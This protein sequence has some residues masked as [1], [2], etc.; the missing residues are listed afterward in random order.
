MTVQLIHAIPGRVRVKVGKLRGAAGPSAHL[1]HALRECDGIRNVSVSTVTA[2]VLVAHSRGIS[3][4]NIADLIERLVRDDAVAPAVGAACPI[5]GGR[6]RDVSSPRKWHLEH[7]DQVL[8]HFGVSPELGLAE[9]AVPERRAAHGHNRLPAASGRNVPTILAGQLTELPVALTAG[10]ALLALVSGGIGEA[11]LLVGIALLNAL[12]GT[13]V[14]SHAE[15]ILNAV[16]RAV[17]LRARVVRDG[18]ERELPFDQVVVGDVLELQA[19]TRIAADARVV[20]ARH[21][22]V[23]EAALTGES[24][25]VRKS[26]EPL[27]VAAAPISE[28][29]NMVYRGTLVVEGSGRAVVVAAGADTV[30]GRLQAFLGTLVPPEARVAREVQGLMRRCLKSGLAAAAVFAAVGALRGAGLLAIL[31]G[32][33]ALLASA[34]PAGLSTLTGGAFAL[35]QRDLRRN[36]I[37]VRRLRALGNL[38]GTQVVCFDKTG[39]LTLNR[40]TVAE[41][42]LPTGA[43]LRPTAANGSPAESISGH[44]GA[45]W[46][47]Q[48]LSLCNEARR[49]GDDPSLEGSS[50]EKALVRMAERTGLDVAAIRTEHPALELH[51]RNGRRPFME[52]LHRWGEQRRLRITKGS[53]TEVL[54]RCNRLHV[55][56]GPQPMSAQVREQVEAQNFRMAGSGQRVLGAAYRWEEDSAS[57]EGDD[58][59]WAGLVGLR[60]PVRS[61]A[62]EVIS[63]LHRAGIRTAV[64]TGDQSLTAHRIG[65]ELGLAGGDAL[66]I[67]DAV[68][69][70]N[71]HS[72]GLRSVVTRT[73]VFARLSPTQKLQVIQAYQHAGLSVVMVGDGFNDVLALKVADVGV[74][75]GR[76]SAELAKRTADLVLE[77]DDLAGL[78]RAIANGRAFFDNVRS[79]L[80]Y[81]LTSAHMDLAAALA[82]RS[83]WVGDV[84]PLQS[85]WTNLA[86]LALAL[87]PREFD[88]PGPPQ[89][90]DGTCLLTQE[91]TRRA[92]TDAFKASASAGLAAAMEGAGIAPQAFGRSIAV[93]QLLYASRCRACARTCRSPNRLL[94]ATTRL[95]AGGYAAAA[96]VQAGSPGGAVANLL[97]L[98]A[99]AWISS[100][101][102]GGGTTPP[103]I[104]TDRR[105][106]WESKTAKETVG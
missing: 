82:S 100:R 39:T 38:A 19:G 43:V 42:R 95:V 15:L 96:L 73:H 52:T 21:L 22:S 90:A 46:L 56:G 98:A 48:L 61:N 99:G 70:K 49:H 97:A 75:M 62:R 85:V 60:D 37:L 103:E 55:D 64:I 87:E 4:Q 47:L 68:D 1:A 51:P 25:P 18:S 71:L 53:P 28:R 3:P 17:D 78:P 77:D 23:D 41:M 6:L 65:E 101:W 30:L 91:D 32:T 93:N 8:R 72:E 69:L 27:S 88:A 50:T 44:A 89:P 29:W 9:G 7:P 92:L 80:G 76:R 16:R 81:V 104:E 14:E 35:A 105:P 24:I 40:M 12:I 57:A 54:E 5:E 106:A 33:L 66:R 36:H 83:G 13:V 102:T 11:A 58:W 67:L 94:D 74:A 2:T 79:S 59:V 63:E 45:A 10:A 86:C 34:V 84:N 31:R 20:H 26:A